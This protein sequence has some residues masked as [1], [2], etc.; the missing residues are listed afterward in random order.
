MQRAIELIV[1]ARSVINVF[2]PFVNGAFGRFYATAELAGIGFGQSRA[3]EG[4]PI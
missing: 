4:L 2:E 3:I 1:F